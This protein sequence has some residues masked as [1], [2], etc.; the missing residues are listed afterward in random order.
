MN[1][2][3]LT[4][5]T[6]Q[7]FILNEIQDDAIATHLAV[8]SNC[9]EKLEKYQYLIVGISKMAPET[10]SFDVTAVV[11]DKIMI[12][13][14]QE[15]RRQEWIFWGLLTILLLVISSFSIPFIPKILAVFYSIPVF[16][17]L[18]ILGTGLVVLLF[19]L[20]DIN[21]QYRMKEEKIFKNDLQPI[22]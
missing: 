4:D 6:L 10:F 15:S 12:Y 1:N 2:E 14:R 22:L 21:K 7:A 20:A 8:C 11:M 18:L 19:L 17:T 3:H 5:E 9:R 16:K 13:E